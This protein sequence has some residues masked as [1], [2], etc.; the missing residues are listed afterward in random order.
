MKKMVLMAALLLVVAACGD[1]GDSAGDSGGRTGGTGDDATTATAAQ[2]PG[3][4]EIAVDGV[5]GGNT[6]ILLTM[7]HGGNPERP[8][9]VSCAQID[10]DPWSFSGLVYPIEGDH[11]CALGTTPIEFEPGTYQAT[12][13]VFTGGA[14]SPDQ[15]AEVEFEVD[16]NTTV[17]APAL[18]A[19]CDL[20]F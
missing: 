11:P 10:A 4:V 13:G 20:E 18:V 1:D 2:A 8:L 5:A 15:C 17:T 7:I 16:G 12:F 19:P 9:G 3:Q 6:Q 14:R